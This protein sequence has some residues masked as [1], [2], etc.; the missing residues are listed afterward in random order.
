M[1]MML[2]RKTI[3]PHSFNSAYACNIP[4]FVIGSYGGPARACFQQAQRPTQEPS[5]S[6]KSYIFREGK[7]DV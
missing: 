5:K 4:L 3:I 6:G 1:C 2:I 7:G